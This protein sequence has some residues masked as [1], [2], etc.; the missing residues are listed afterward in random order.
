M[1]RAAERA[2]LLS[3]GVAGS[4]ARSAGGSR[5]SSPLGTLF[6]EPGLHPWTK[7]EPVLEIL[8]RGCSLIALSSGLLLALVSLYLRKVSPLIES[9]TLALVIGFGLLL[10]A[11]IFLLL[12]FEAYL[13]K[14]GNLP[15]EASNVMSKIA[16]GTIAFAIA[17]CAASLAWRAANVGE[18]DDLIKKPV[19][20]F[21]GRHPDALCEYEMRHG[22]SGWRFACPE[23]IVPPRASADPA[24]ALQRL[25]P[26]G[27]PALSNRAP[28]YPVI[29]A[30][31]RAT[32]VGLVGVC[33]ALLAA[34]A[35]GALASAALARIAAHNRAALERAIA[36]PPLSL[37]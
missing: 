15:E 35:A 1:E 32:D 4:R 9:K 8:S 30:E 31:S 13:N 11:S 6:E 18:D 27:C 5:G 19:L 17:I 20:H 29:A 12:G 10:T 36:G 23:T 21:A 28:C 26:A 24:K 37:L 25:C 2:P 14:T 7:L 33:L 3:A 16:T 22:C 34:R